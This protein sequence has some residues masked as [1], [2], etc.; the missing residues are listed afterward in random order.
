MHLYQDIKSIKNLQWWW[1]ALTLT[2]LYTEL[3]SWNVCC[4]VICNM[5]RKGLARSNTRS[6]YIESSSIINNQKSKKTKDVIENW[7]FYQNLPNQ[8]K[9]TRKT[10]KNEKRPKRKTSKQP[11]STRVD[12]SEQY[13]V[14]SSVLVS[15]R[16]GGRGRC[17]ECSQVVWMVGC[18]GGAWCVVI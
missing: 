18:G 17:T 7:N 4:H 5:N 13:S 14:P 12:S 11:P 6:L 16:E 15:R 10:P 1:L 8:P 3:K 9:L 2:A